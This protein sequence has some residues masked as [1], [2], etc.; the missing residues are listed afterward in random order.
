MLQFY[1]R[2]MDT[3]DVL[4]VGA[5]ISGLLAA[6][7][8]QAAGL[9]VL[10]VDKGR[11]PGGRMSTRRGMGDTR[12]DH[13][14]QFFT[15][16][17]PRWKVWVERMQTEGVVKEWFR[18]APWDSNP[19]GYPRFI[20]SDGM[21]AVP[22]FL[23]R[24]LDL[25]RS[26]RIHSL[27]RLK[28]VWL[29]ESEGGEVFKAR[30][31]VLSTPLPQTWDLLE[32][33]ELEWL[34]EEARA[35]LEAVTYEKGLATLVQLSGPSE[36]P[37]PGCLKLDQDAL[38]WIAD[39]QQKGISPEPALTLHASAAFAERHWDTSDAERGQLMLEAA[40]RWL[41]SEVVDFTCHRWGF[42]LPLKPLKKPFYRHAALNLTLAGDAFGGPRVEGAALSGIEAAKV[43]VG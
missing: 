16:R 12:I 35:D 3:K 18:K 20:G 5:G 39:N 40:E 6:T 24:E 10:V 31:L 2:N 13:G 25:L 22:K 4:V 32:T 30:E 14:A 9:N 26:V 15:V 41:G 36:V 28:G 19:E 34:S 43:L 38:I 1:K 37:A 33:S 27:K 11:G 7:E 8:M 21:N 29:A 23:A 17:D 42:T